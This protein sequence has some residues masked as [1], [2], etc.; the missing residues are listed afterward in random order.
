M[1]EREAGKSVDSWF[2]LFKA[3]HYQGA[4][5]IVLRRRIADITDQYIQDTETLL[6]KFL[7]QPVQLVYIK[8]DIKSGMIDVRVGQYGESY[9]PNRIRNLPIFFRIIG[10]STPMNRI[11]SLMLPN[12]RYIFYDECIANIRGGEKYLPDEAFRIKEIYT[13]YNREAATP[14]KIYMCGN[15]YSVYN[16]IW[17]DLG[18]DTRKVKPGALIVGKDYVINCFRIPDELKQRILAANPMYEFDNSYAKYAFNGE[19]ISDMNI[20]LWKT[21]PKSFKLMFVFKLGSEYLSVHSG[22]TPSSK[23]PMTWWVC[24][25]DPDWLNKHKVG[26]GRKLYCFSFNDLVSG[27]VLANSS[28]DLLKRFST[29]RNAVAK[30][31]VGYNCVDA[32][33]LIEDIYNLI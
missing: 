30:R 22:P 26:K 29:F 21:E 2:K 15:P 5:S 19:A 33:Y 6:N 14:I 1:C 13:T 31:Q 18:V 16:P 24:K 3:F 27:S 8:G 9:S 7:D 11:K 10:L 4:P 20:R 32:E 17:S 25:H 23:D 28:A 12:V